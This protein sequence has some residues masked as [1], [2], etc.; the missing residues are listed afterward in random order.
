MADDRVWRTL[1]SPVRELLEGT[2][3][4]V[5]VL[6]TDLRYVYVNTALARLNGAPAADHIG[7]TIAEIVPGIDARLDVLRAVLADG[8]PRETTSSG[9]TR[10]PSPL[11]RRYF[12]GA[13]HRLEV[14]GTVVGLAG[15]VLEVTASRQQQNE[16][17]RARERL[18]MLDSA[19]T[20]IGT[21]LDMD[22]TC[23]ELARF[24]V[25][26]LGDAASVDVLPP[27]DA[28]AAHTLPG[29]LR[30][31]RASLVA[32]PELEETA[33]A[34]GK[35][36]EHIDH[37]PGSA[38]RRALESGRPVIENMPSDD[39]LGRAAAHPDRLA[40]LRRGG[41]HSGLVV[42]LVARGRALGTVTLIRAGDSPLFTQDDTVVAADLAL[43]AAVSIDNAR[44]F[45]REHGIALDLQRALL[46]EP[47]APHPGLEVAFRYRPAG[48]SALVGGD[49][50][51]TVARPD[52]STLLAI[53]DVM[54]HSLE[55]AV[56][57]SHYQAMLRMVAAGNLPPGR[58]LDRMDRLTAP[59]ATG[60][61][62]TCL[63]LVM[64]PETGTCT[65]AS[66][67]HLPPALV[68]P[69]GTVRLLPVEPG[70]P[71]AAGFSGFPE[72]TA[73]CPPGHHLLLYTDGLVERRD[74]AIDASLA[75][76]THLRLPPDARGE[77]LLDAVLTGL[78]PTADDD[79]ALLTATLRT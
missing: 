41:V 15:I 25:P 44:R 42:P 60:R 50:Y 23:V 22:T 14:D 6:D 57:M 73:Q 37:Q 59:L 58:V 7:R 49:F 54:G 31:R 2:P 12:H 27:E 76:L 5:G 55:A 72:A 64:S 4:A 24:L 13:Y 21:T 19:S 75:R 77:Q 39:R 51:E 36:G 33:A 10:V 1:P 26:E 68:A 78:S 79:V 56:E 61:P 28:P 16:L 38:A 62:A 71:L 48:A 30:L 40:A 65:F 74:E 63:A 35:A 11:A 66:A 53:G 18:A 43:R 70:P 34:L 47:G 29:V 8:V 69:D 3:G 17:E 52:G 9:Q 46:A 45:T 20:R 32:V 67:G